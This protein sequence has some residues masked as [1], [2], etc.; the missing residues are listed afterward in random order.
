LGL[1]GLGLFLGTIVYLARLWW[2]SRHR[3][4]AMTHSLFASLLAYSIQSLSDYQLDNLCITGTL[5]IFL[6]AIASDLNDLKAPR[7]PILGEEEMNRNLSRSIALMIGGV[8]IAA[9]LWLIPVQR[10]WM[11]SSQGFQALASI[12][13]SDISQEQKQAAIVQFTQNLEE[14]HKLAPWEP[15]YPQQLGWVLGD[16][17]LKANRPD[18]LEQSIRWLNIARDSAPHQEFVFSSLGWLQLNTNPK[19]ASDAFRKAAQLVPAKR[20]VFYG[21]G[22]SLLFQNRM[23]I[24]IEALALEVVRDPIALT[25]PWWQTPQRRDLFQQVIKRTESIY[26][27]LINQASN[28]S[29]VTHLQACRSTLRWW[30]G[31][32]EGAKADAIASQF[33]SMNAVLAL[34]SNQPVDLS[35]LAAKPYVS[36]STIATLTA[37]LDP[38]QREAQLQKAWIMG[39]K[40]PIP[41][42][43]IARLQDSMAQSKSFD[44]W[45]KQKAPTRELRRQRSGFGVLSRHIDGVIPSDFLTVEENLATTYLMRDITYEWKYYPE[46]EKILQVRREKILGAM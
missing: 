4:S 43:M 21:L 9:M 29:L 8:T 16:L 5:V 27:E 3:L 28:P 33:H 25:N 12:E 36:P 18:Y 1:L 44:Q 19:A 20:G 40:Q 38:S 14:A 45:L 10:A 17:G 11:F 7:T 31:N 34:Q 37:W 32:F 2:L 13:D 35:V 39:V 23:D 30:T 41:S 46:L 42:G 15:Y 22:M 26:T 24:A 6:A